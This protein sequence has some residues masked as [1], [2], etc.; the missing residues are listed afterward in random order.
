MKVSAVVVSTMDRPIGEVLDSI[1]PHVEELIVV[2]GHAGVWERWLAAAHARHEVV[3]TQDDD[4]L[5]DVPAVL[6]AYEPGLVTCNMPADRRPEYQDG[7][8][9]VGWGAVFDRKAT[10]ATHYDRIYKEGPISWHGDDGSYEPFVRYQL[11]RSGLDLDLL[12]PIF[13]SECDR[14]FTGLSRLK[15][16]DVPFLHDV[17]AHGKDRMGRRPCH[18]DYMKAI[19]QRIYDAREI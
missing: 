10:Y 1:I 7:I 13:L 19:R 18:G 4:A 2:R 16:I 5:V 11:Y 9:L 3:Y 17:R 14:V 12:D 6:A 15:L 8:A